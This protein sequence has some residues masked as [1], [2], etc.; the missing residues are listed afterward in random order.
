MVDPINRA[1][2]DSL[3]AFMAQQRMP[4]M[5]A[6]EWH[7]LQILDGMRQSFDSFL[8]ALDDREKLDYVRL[9]RAWI[10]AEK[11]MEQALLQ[12]TETFREQ[13]LTS[14][15]GEL[16]KLTGQEIDPTVARIHT[17]Y[18]QPG[19]R[20]QRAASVDEGV[21]KVASLTFWDAASMNYSGLS[22][23]SYPGHTSVADASYLD[24]GINATAGQFIQLVRRLDIGGQLRTHLDQALLANAVLG[25]CIMRLATAEFEFALIEA[26]KNSADSRVDRYKYQQIKRALAGEAQWGLMEEMLLFIPHGVDNVSWV[27]QSIGLTGQYVGPPRGAHMTIPHLVFSVRGCQGAFSFFPNRPGGSLRHHSSHREACEE[28]HVAFNAFYRAGKVDWLYPVMLLRDCAQLKQIAEAAPPPP[29][30]DGVAKL[31]YT[32]AHAIPKIDRVNK[33]GYVRNSVQKVP[34]AS[35]CD[36]Y[37]TRCRGNLQELANETPGFMSTLIEL[38]QTLIDEILN[39]LLIPVPGAVRGLARIRTFAMFVALEQALVEGGHKAAEGNPGEFLQSVF[40]LADLLISSRL[41]TRLSR[42]VQRRHQRL[43]HQL[44][45]QRV[46]VADH[47]VL[48]SPQIL[49]RMLGSQDTLARDMQIVLGTSSTSRHALNQVWEGAT[50]SASLVDAVH[51]LRADRL[52]DWV[53]EGADPARPSPV[54]TTE[55]MAPLLTQLARWPVGTALSIENHQG[56]EVRRYSKSASSPVTQVVAVTQLENYQFAYATPRQITAHFS[57]AIVAL[58]PAIFAGGEQLL[59]QQL[60][61]YA[62]TVKLALFEALTRYAEGS[63]FTLM[64]ANTLVRRLL[65]DRVHNQH[66]VPAVVAQLQVL[67]PELS[68]VRL[69]EVLREHPLSEHQQTQLL[70]SQLQPEGLYEALRAARQVV[71]RE[72][73]LDGVFRARR[74]NR[75][76]QNWAAVF[77]RIVLR[78]VTGRALVVSPAEQVVPYVARGRDDR[79]IVVIDQRSGHFSPF[80]KDGLRAGATLTGA[81]SFYEAIINQLSEDESLILGPNTQQAVAQFRYLVAQAM[82][83]SRASDGSFYLGLREIEQ[84]ASTLDVFNAALLPDTLGLYSL[85]ANHYVFIEG[86]FFKVARGGA[87]QTWRIQHP[88]L[89]D[90]YAPALIHNGAG[91]WRHEWEKPLTWDGQKPFYRLG[92]LTRA[93]SPDAIEQIQ[94]IS[95]VTSDL[96]RRVQVRNEP[97]PFMLVETIERFNVQQRVKAGMDAG[98]DFYDEVLGEVGADKAGDLVGRAGASRTEQIAELETRVRQGKPQM[99]QLFFKALCH[100]SEQSSDPLSQVLQRHFPSLTAAVAENL[101]RQVN[102]D[103][104][105]SLE[106]GRV[107]LSLTPFVRWHIKD[108]RKSRALE[109][110][111]WPAAA[112]PDSA[113]LIL[114]TLP[115]IEGWPSRLRVEVWERGRLIDSIGPVDAVLKRIMEPVAGHYQAYAPQPGGGRLPIAS[116]GP[117]LGTL[118]GALPAIERQAFGYNHASGI[119]ELTQEI[120]YRLDRQRASLNTLLGIGGRV[121]YNLPRRVAD[122][123]VG[124]PLSGGEP[125]PSGRTQVAR[126]R[127]LFP[128]MT[129]ADVWDLLRDAGDSVADRDQIID[130]LFNERTT[131]DAALQEWHDGASAD[132]ADNALAHSRALAV[133]R[134]QR[135]WAK[136]GLTPGVVE[137]LNLDGLDL[138]TLPT[139]TAHFGHVTVLSLRG[140]HLTE[141]PARFLRSFPS[142]R[143]IYLNGNQLSQLPEMQGVAYLTMLNLAHNQLKFNLR[144]DHRLGALTQLRVLDVSF[145]PLGQGRQLSFYR[146]TNLQELNLRA[147]GINRLPRG[148][149]ALRSLRSFDLRDNQISELAQTDLFIYPQVHQ[150]MNFRGNPL[151]LEARQL[152][153]R[154]GERHGRPDIDFGLWESPASLDQRPNRWLALLPPGE[155]QGR[156][157]DWATLQEQPMADYFFELLANIADCPRFIEPAYR[158]LRLSV[159]ARI[160]ALI[161]DALLHDGVE[162]IATLPAY[163]YMNGGIDGWLLCLHELELRALP[164]GLL[165]ADVQQA[166]SAF[167]HYYRALRRIDSLNQQIAEHFDRQTLLHTCTRILSYRIALAAS[168]DLPQVLSERFDAPTAVPDARSINTLRQNILREEQGVNWPDWL[169]GKHYWLAFLERKYAARFASALKGFDRSLESATNKVGSGVMKEGEYLNYIAVL[170]GARQKVKNALIGQM[171][172]EEWQDFVNI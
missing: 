72:A 13:A 78:D 87:L 54:G 97:P 61:A 32:L 25:R 17:R 118:L 170:Q 84:Y 27:P 119:E 153:R 10:D 144:D 134:I 68:V 44:A 149:V 15:R 45:Q 70:H 51:R 102:A 113:R 73:T 156:E 14:L 12:L 163:R 108:L 19:G 125:G 7:A 107:P 34:I 131:L 57:H 41:H 35:L 22:G 80:Y 127:E 8:G 172:L 152:L 162:M 128:S 9:Q 63:R 117:F 161:D 114:Q 49:E 146:L 126:M 42:G 109:G 31:L 81:D 30:L 90:A 37:I 141:L 91:S 4:L 157:R 56:L 106:A 71:R 26:L 40:D 133:A 99:E 138:A 116:P 101:V 46:S 48:T 64:G 112:N 69:L 120:G 121:W 168:L 24:A 94:H 52:I 60:A 29:D 136:E 75:Q 142:L 38:F 122:G 124:Y 135:C 92:P 103:E 132:V 130:Y 165:A 150:G 100:T 147:T 85:A 88:V 148:A 53:V 66:P 6:P 23:W 105:R 58:L 62:Q 86:T 160:W 98:A 39:L 21:V 11:A 154:I 16:R 95:G 143:V 82:L 140:N 169:Q 65:P 129:D 36:F 18:L 151:S 47:Q 110:V 2:P 77:A 20:V 28:F 137:E 59:R 76:T 93:L 43:Y 74:F 79:T 111:Y 83:R 171:T 167:L 123:R 96:L 164:R 104:Q 159:T 5:A 55:V 67:H 155:V 145:N 3:A 50:P 89:S 139:L 166:G 115:G 158:S 1:A 33:I